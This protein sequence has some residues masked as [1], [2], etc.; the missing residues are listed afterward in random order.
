MRSIQSKLFVVLC[1]VLSSLQVLAQGDEKRKNVLFFL[2]DDLRPNLRCYGDQRALTPNIDRLAKQ[3]I[4]FNNAHCQQAVCSPSRTSM[5]TG[6]R[7]DETGV[8]DLQSHFRDHV[9]HA[10]TLPQRF[11]N[12]G[13]FTTGV[14]KIFHNS[15]NTLDPISWTKEVSPVSGTTYVLPENRHGGGKQRITEMADVPDT[16]YADGMIAEGAICL[17][18]EANQ[19]DDPFF[20]AVGFKKPHAPFCAPRRYW[21]LYDRSAFRATD[22]ARP[23]GS[24]DL[25]FH[26][27]QELRGYNDIPDEGGISPE[28]EQEI[29]HGYYAC[30]SYV[31][32]QIGKVMDRLETLGLSDNTVIVLWG[33]H[34]YHLGEQDLWCK[35]TNF[36]LDTRV[37]LIVAS[38]GM[39]GNGS[40]TDAMVESVDIY[41]TLNDLCGIMP[42]D[43]L[44]GISLR[45]LLDNPSAVWGYPAFSQFVRPYQAI[46]KKNRPTHMGYSVRL[47]GWRCTYWYDLEKNAVVERELYRLDGHGPERENVTG[48]HAVSEVEAQLAVL[49]DQ[50]SHNTYVK[51][52]R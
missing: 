15:K 48:Q 4:L 25:A 52:S 2:V 29:I 40:K 35:S 42:M 8:Y 33:D 38:P 36:E 39:R 10:I 43:G 6:L 22:K 45:P 19:L 51:S 12:Q 28:Q 18:E 20:I 41:P 1:L 16:A 47:A 32:T 26:Q 3:G 50:Y 44:S 49:I 5:L 37:P 46:L 17:L 24:P 34:G 9:P 11:K 13:Y 23:I 30:I 7:P 27:W 14:G 21:D 31:D